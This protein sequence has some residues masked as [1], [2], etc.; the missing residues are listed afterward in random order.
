M[1]IIVT[2]ATGYIGS[3]I[4]GQL[5]QDGHV[6]YK[7][8]R[9]VADIS[10]FASVRKF[11]DGIRPEI[12]VH[13]AAVSDIKACDNDREK[14][15]KANI[16][17]TKC[18]A[19]SCAVF[20]VRLVYLSTDQVYNYFEN[21]PLY[22]YVRPNPTNFYGITKLEGEHAVQ[23]TVT[24]HHILRLSWQFGAHEQGLPY[25]GGIYE[26]A[27]NALKD[28]ATIQ[29]S[30]GGTRHLTWVYDT[31]DVIR[32]ATNMELPF[33]IYNVACKN[34]MS[35][36]ET[37]KFVFNKLGA[38][39]HDISSLLVEDD[40]IMPRRLSAEPFNLYN[41]G[42][43]LPTFEQSFENCLKLRAL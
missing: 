9:D 23:A 41:A 29:L 33:G 6:V 30:K 34:T 19:S 39:A 36:Y 21:V 15:A 13:A 2:G 42:Y 8:S 37:Y 14:A 5:R 16:T 38:T 10:D 1:K 18:I 31:I 32:A 12:V 27:V 4:A 20:G 43:K 35:D 24:M 26:S 28:K 40:D 3:R 7:L 11:F 17:G 22:E 25:R